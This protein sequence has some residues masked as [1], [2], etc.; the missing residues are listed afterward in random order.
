MIQPTQGAIYFFS[1]P[2]VPLNCSSQSNQASVFNHNLTSARERDKKIFTLI[3]VLCNPYSAAACFHKRAE[4]EVCG[5]LTPAA[6][7]MTVQQLLAI[8][9]RQPCIIPLYHHCILYL[10]C[11]DDIQHVGS[12][13]CLM[14]CI[15]QPP[16]WRLQHCSVL[17]VS[18]QP[19]LRSRLPRMEV[20]GSEILARVL[21]SH[22]LPSP[23][24]TATRTCSKIWA[25][26]WILLWNAF[27]LLP[28]K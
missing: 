26:G 22:Q 27:L 13:L 6:L 23:R 28:L 19:E 1:A 14:C 16:A 20:P 8:K 7:Y 18:L 21:C 2:S 9:W 15:L 11:Y 10:Q 12:L 24:P 5:V 3:C 25:N 4:D 17:F